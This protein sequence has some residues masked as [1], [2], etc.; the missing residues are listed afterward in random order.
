M[1]YYGP[2][3]KFFGH[4]GRHVEHDVHV[5]VPARDEREPAAEPFAER[6]A[7]RAAG[8]QTGSLSGKGPYTGP[9]GASPG[10]GASPPHRG[11]GVPVGHVVARA[12]G[13]GRA[14]WGNASANGFTGGAAAQQ[15]VPDSTAHGMG[16]LYRPQQLQRRRLRGASATAASASSATDQHRHPARRPIC[17]WRRGRRRQP[18]THRRTHHDP[19]DLRSP[20]ACCGRRGP[21]LLARLPWRRGRASR[22]RRI[23]P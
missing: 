17:G 5:A 1:F 20:R 21:D 8:R 10:D 23:C 22:P 7:G 12:T 3:L 16:F 11:D 4:H 14:I 9:T 6:T 18:D 13:A 15:P 2:G 19:D